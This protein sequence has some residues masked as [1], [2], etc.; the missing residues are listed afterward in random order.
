M[1]ECLVS[2]LDLFSLHNHA[3]R[4]GSLDLR[5]VDVP[6]LLCTTYQLKEQMNKYHEE[7]EQL[8]SS[9]LSPNGDIC[10]SSQLNGTNEEQELI[11]TRID[12]LEKELDQLRSQLTKFDDD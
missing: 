11:R 10:Y 6:R 5:V 4:S 3:S 1:K 8:D 7:Q 9:M 12:E 2:L